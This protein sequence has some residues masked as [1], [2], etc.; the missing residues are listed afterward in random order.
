[1]KKLLLIN[2]ALAATLAATMSWADDD[3]HD[4]VADW[5]PKETLQ[6]HIEAKGWEVRKIKVDDGCYE[7]K[8]FD[9]NGN[10]VE[11]EYYPASLR[12]REVQIKFAEDAVIPDHLYSGDN[13]GQ[14]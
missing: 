10:K 11:A 13:G 14:P 9:Q 4:P 6:Q 2:T 1:M 3:C 5:Q 7:V 12:L 8:G